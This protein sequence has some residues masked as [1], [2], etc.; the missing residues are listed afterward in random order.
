MPAV[1][2]S[3]I[4]LNL[5][6]VLDVLLRERSVGLAADRLNLTS[7]AVSHALKRLRLLF[8]NELLV[9][10]GRRMVPTARGQSLAEKLPILLA[11]VEQTLAAPEQFDATKSTRSFRLAAPDF[12]SPLLPRL[13]ESVAKDA[14][15]VSVEIAAFSP[16]VALDMQQGRYDALIAPSFKQSAELRGVELGSWPWVTFGRKDHPGFNG[17]SPEKWAQFPHVQVSASSPSGGNPIDLAALTIGTKRHIGAVVPHFSMAA[18]ILCRTDMLL[19]VPSIAMLETA[20]VYDLASRDLPFEIP[21]LQL[22]LF[23]SAK[24]GDE[25]EIRWFRKHITDAVRSLT[26]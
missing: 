14:P 26:S 18:P 12:I 22:S 15:G 16:T 4:D 13:L 9:R 5:L 21:P 17:W 8:D 24:S 7:S 19:T 3:N 1:P 10:D 25:P 11:Q 6:V 23:H 2:L 20:Q